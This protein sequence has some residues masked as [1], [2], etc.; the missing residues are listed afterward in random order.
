MIYIKSYKMFESINFDNTPNDEVDGQKIR[1]I[2][3]KELE[4]F[5]EYYISV[6]SKYYYKS[7]RKFPYII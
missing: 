1:V 5:I 7:D 4:V 2:S 6:S 3:K